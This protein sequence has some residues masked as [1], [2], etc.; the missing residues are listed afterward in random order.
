[1]PSLLLELVGQEVDDHLVEVVATEVGVAV[2][3]EHLEDAFGEIEDRDVVGA[4][5]EVVDGDLL[6][7]LLVE[8]IGQGRGGRLVDDALDRQTGDLAGI[9][10]GLA[11]AVVEVGRDGDH[12][13]VDL[14]AEVRL[15]IG[16]QLLQD[17]RR[18]FL[19]AVPAVAHLDL[20]AAVLAPRGSCTG[21]ARGPC[22]TTRIVE[23]AAHE[24]LDREDGVLRVGD[25]LPPGKAADQPLAAAS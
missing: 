21:P 22:W 15:G 8:T 5:T 10:G 17:H 24:P 23:L 9:L 1:M 25:R 7:V 16:L 14:L 13:A 18:D 3:G 12:G 19:R 20:D 4:A 2:G 11:L 6:V